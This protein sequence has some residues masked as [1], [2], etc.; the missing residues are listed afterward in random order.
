MPFSFVYFGRKRSLGLSWVILMPP[1]VF[2]LQGEGKQKL[3]G[4]WAK[5]MRKYPYGSHIWYAFW[6]SGY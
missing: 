1:N 4:R 5:L 6:K 2:V 3:R